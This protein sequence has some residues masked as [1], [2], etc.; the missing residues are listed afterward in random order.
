[1]VPLLFK[2]TWA[3]AIPTCG[4]LFLTAHLTLADLWYEHL[5]WPLN[6]VE[7]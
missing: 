1:M 3:S 7:Q 5:L 2:V 6:K 4:R